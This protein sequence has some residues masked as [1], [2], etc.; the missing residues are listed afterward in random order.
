MYLLSN[1]KELTIK[2]KFA[3]FFINNKGNSKLV[4]VKVNATITCKDGYSLTT[5]IY[6]TP[7]FVSITGDSTALSIIDTVY[8]NDLKLNNISN[9]PVNRLITPGLG[10]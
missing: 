10:R 2:I 5:K 6:P 7:T 3:L 4:P 1:L 9:I 8:T